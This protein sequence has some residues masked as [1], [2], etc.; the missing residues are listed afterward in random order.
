MIIT[1]ACSRCAAVTLILVSTAVLGRG[2][3]SLTVV[4]AVQQVLA[5]HPSIA[6]AEA[7][8]RSAEA[9]RGQ[10]EGG[11]LP[12]AELHA[13]YTRIG[14]VPSLTFP[15]LGE[16]TL[17]PE[18]NYDTH[19]G[20]S[21]TLFDFGKTRSAVDLAEAHVQSTRDQVRL[22][23]TDL[24]F[25][26]ISS[27][28]TILLLRQSLSVADEE[29]SA[30]SDHLSMVRAKVETGSATVLDSLNVVVRVAGSREQREELANHLAK[31]EAKFRQLLGLSDDARLVL[32]GGFEAA[33][34]LA[35]ADSLMRLAAAQRPDVQLAHDAL[36]AAVLQQSVARSGNLP[37][38]R[39]NGL[40]GA[41]NGYIPDLN[42][43]KA[44]WMVGVEL[45]VPVFDGHRTS[46][47]EE[48]A[49]AGVM[50]SQAHESELWR[51]VRT[52]VVASLSDL[53]TAWTKVEISEAEVKQATAAT[54]IARTK[55][56]SGSATNIDVLDAQTA[57]SAAKL[58]RL[59]A[60]YAYVLS[61]YSLE[62]AVGG[63]LF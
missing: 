10:L 40:V 48:E 47:A 11:F 46:Y 57:E 20:A 60:L 35:D 31:E 6:K 37:S 19:I 7:L 5:Q 36:R 17:Y 56:E 50:A 12:D 8:V 43:W 54:R 33:R 44:N 16:F 34:V 3:D 2:Q 38:L 30:L 14:P 24:A 32:R 22:S 53:H 42:I 25:E 29:L 59:Q 49:Q 4:S 27:F 15:G 62:R 61:R 51:Q 23:K 52:D 26:T 63:S 18:N 13:A 1:D 39:V 41:K 58:H 28:Y 55:F 45:G 21:Y 9:H